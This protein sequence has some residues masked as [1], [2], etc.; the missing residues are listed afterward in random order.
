MDRQCFQGSPHPCHPWAKLLR[1]SSCGGKNVGLGIRILSLCLWCDSD[2]L[3]YLKQVSYPQF[4]QQKNVKMGLEYFKG[5]FQQLYVCMWRGEDK[6]SRVLHS[7]IELWV[8]VKH[9][10]PRVQEPLL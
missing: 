9:S 4:P 6:E 7:K 5:L 8:E 1:G 10:A 2:L 3:C